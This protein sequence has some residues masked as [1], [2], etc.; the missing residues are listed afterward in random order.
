MPIVKKYY[1][2]KRKYKR[3]KRARA[4]VSK[5]LKKQLNKLILKKLD[6]AQEDKYM[7]PDAYTS[8]RPGDTDDNASHFGYLQAITPSFPRGTSVSERIGD[9]VRVKF[10]SLIMTLCGHNYSGGVAT[11]TSNTLNLVPFANPVKIHVFRC[12][13]G[14]VPTVP[15]LE[16]KYRRQ[17][18]WPQDLIQ[19][20]DEQHIKQSIQKL[21][22]T[23][24]VLKYKQMFGNI[25]DNSTG[26][27][28]VECTLYSIPQYSYKEI[29]IPVNEKWEIN[30]ANNEPMKWG[31]YLFIDYGYQNWR[32]PYDTTHL[33]MPNVD[34]RLRVVFEDA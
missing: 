21:S 19:E 22:T 16:G 4:K 25:E 17:G 9:R 15:L 18:L 29:H 2:K 13:Q 30:E 33:A 26:T 27:P 31:Y 28:V 24:C 12:R 5:N 6:D 10:M 32:R 14:V 1:K 11:N 3:K 34:F 20:V 7:I 23:T 8:L